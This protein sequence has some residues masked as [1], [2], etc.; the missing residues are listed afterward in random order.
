MTR[1]RDQVYLLHG[2][3]ASEFMTVF[4]DTVISRSEPILKQYERAVPLDTLPLGNV[5]PRPT[6][7]VEFDWDANAE[8]WFREEEI[9]ALRRYFAKY[10]YRDNLT[11]HE[12]MKPRALQHLD[13]EPFR[14]LRNVSRRTISNIFKILRA[15]NV[16]TGEPPN[17]VHGGRRG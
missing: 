11:F 16:I 3:S 1:G 17:G 12:W 10:V 5:R 2:E 8:A 7:R 14:Q 15:K 4:G 6:S 13:F 9:E